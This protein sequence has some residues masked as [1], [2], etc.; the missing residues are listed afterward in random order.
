MALLSYRKNLFE[1]FV[2]LERREEMPIEIPQEL[3]EENPLFQIGRK[4]GLQEGRR[5][6]ELKLL[7]KAL[8][9]KFPTLYKKNSFKDVEKLSTKSIDKI[10][11]L[12][13][14]SD[15]PEEII[16]AIQKA[17]KRSKS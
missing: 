13:L 9:E 2:E 5:E 4:K 12:T 8:K 1:K 15:D 14:K 3:I 11:L 7:K 16:S 6:G 17:I 10:F